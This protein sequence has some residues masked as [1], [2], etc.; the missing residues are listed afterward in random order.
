MFWARPELEMLAEHY[1]NVKDRGGSFEIEAALSFITSEFKEMTIILPSL[2]PHFISFEYLWAILPPDCLVVGKDPLNFDRIWC[3]R[4]HFVEESR[5]GISLTMNAESLM[6]DGSKV[7]KVETTL[8]IPLFSGNKLISDLPYAPLKYH[9]KR[10]EV[11][12]SVRERANK[13]LEFWIPEFRHMEHQGT[14]LAEMYD[15]VEP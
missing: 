8:R 13:A 1:R 4:S 10:E 3:V 12:E 11:I 7:G 9:R 5:D 6:W 14:G 15:K 2:V